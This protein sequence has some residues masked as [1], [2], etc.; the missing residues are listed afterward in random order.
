M[1]FLEY[2]QDLLAIGIIEESHSPYAS[3][4]VLVRKKNGELRI[5]VDI[6][7]IEQLD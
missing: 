3:P 4:I 2:L 1:N 7:Q 5:V 6:R